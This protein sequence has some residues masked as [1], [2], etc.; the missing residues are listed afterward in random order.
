[1]NPQVM[2]RA[3]LQVCIE[4]LSKKKRAPQ[5]GSF[6]R[7]NLTFLFYPVYLPFVATDIPT[8]GSDTRQEPPR[9]RLV[10]NVPLGERT[11]SVDK[12]ALHV[13][14][15]AARYRKVFELIADV[16]IHINDTL[17]AVEA[18]E[19]TEKL[20]K[21]KEIFWAKFH[22]HPVWG[23]LFSDHKR[24]ASLV[25]TIENPFI[26]DEELLTLETS[27]E[28]T[29]GGGFGKVL[30]DEKLGTGIKFLDTHQGDPKTNVARF[31]RE[32]KIM[33]ILQ[34]TGILPEFY[35]G[36]V[37]PDGRHFFVMEFLRSQ[38]LE[39]MLQEPLTISDRYALIAE[40]YR[41]VK[42]MHSKNIVHRDLKPRNMM[43]ERKDGQWEVKIIDFGLAKQ[44]DTGDP[45][46]T[47]DIGLTTAL[48]DN[49]RHGPLL[50]SVRYLSPGQAKNAAVVTFENDIYSLGLIA[51]EILKGKATRDHIRAEGDAYAFVDR[52]VQDDFEESFSDSG[53]DPQAAYA[54][55]SMFGIHSEMDIPKVFET[56]EAGGPMKRIVLQTRRKMNRASRASVKAVKKHPVA[57]SLL[58]LII[59]G[60]AVGVGAYAHWPDSPPNGN[61]NGHVDP[62]PPLPSAVVAR[63]LNTPHPERSTWGFTE[64]E[65]GSRDLHANLPSG[66]ISAEP[67]TFKRG[68][69]L[70]R[71]NKDGSKMNIGLISAITSEQWYDFNKQ[72]RKKLN[73][74]VLNYLE[75]E[76]DGKKVGFIQ[77]NFGWFMVGSGEDQYPYGGLP[78]TF[79]DGFTHKRV[80]GSKRLENPLY[81]KFIDAFDTNGIEAEQINNGEVFNRAGYPTSADHHRDILVDQMNISKEHLKK[82][83]QENDEKLFNSMPKEVSQMPRDNSGNLRG[84]HAVHVVPYTR[85]QMLAA[86]KSRDPVKKYTRI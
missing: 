39:E 80:S 77:T 49:E 2:L 41:T 6:F 9:E 85:E 40:L 4:I 70:W 51:D 76:I 44:R 61:G 72:D 20:V 57:A 64:Y 48:H 73:A 15:I 26:S 47:K 83:R 71:K 29:I 86:I 67:L 69:S 66:K 58:A 38:T 1:M 82:W 53:I 8:T 14:Q 43:A 31:E 30:L 75:Q 12:S 3:D 52:M 65:D 84:S 62:P 18:V 7:K 33:Q 42:V 46:A 32:Q 10:Q 34:E 17:S 74:T 60:G 37:S 21:F 63:K 5:W 23:K 16:R 11:I 35:G 54:I 19:E 25:S 45:N 36:G 50:G 27:A 68:A 59:G 56:L 78:F 13:E 79:L 55:E 24:F 22:D 81:R 28:K